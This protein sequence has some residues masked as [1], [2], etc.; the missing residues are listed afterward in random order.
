MKKIGVKFCFQCMTNRLLHEKHTLQFSIN[1]T[2]FPIEGGK[3]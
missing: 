1:N 2:L 3:I